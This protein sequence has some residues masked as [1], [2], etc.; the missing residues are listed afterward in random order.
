MQTHNTQMQ[1]MQEYNPQTQDTQG[2]Q[3]Y[4]THDIQTIQ[5]DIQ[6]IKNTQNTQNTQ[7][8]SYTTTQ[9]DTW[10]VISLKV[11]DTEYNMHLLIEANPIHRNTSIFS[12][13]QELIIP[14]AP[15]RLSDDFPPWRGE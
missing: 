8:N 6:N 15:I 2:V 11:Y 9:G 10:D 7:Q 12:A 14:E 1:Y 3:A 5:S 4:Q 13:N